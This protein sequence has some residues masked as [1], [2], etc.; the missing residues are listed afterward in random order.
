MPPRHVLHRPAQPLWK[1]RRRFREMFL[2]C[3]LVAVPKNDGSSRPVAIGEAFYK[4]A[5]FMALES[6]NGIVSEILGPSQFAFLPGGSETVAIP[7]K[8]TGGRHDY[9]TD[10]SNAYTPWRRTRCSHL[11]TQNPDWSQFSGLWTGLMPPRRVPAS[12]PRAEAQQ[13]LLGEQ[14]SA[15]RSFRHAPLLSWHQ[16]GHRCRT[17]GRREHCEGCR[18]G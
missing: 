16:G 18:C 17:R 10:Q 12:A 1:I 9:A 5:A 13:P 11:Y 4:M 2:G 6:V 3:V 14:H 7:L 15:R 8:A